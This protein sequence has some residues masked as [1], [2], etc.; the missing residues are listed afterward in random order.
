MARVIFSKHDVAAG[1][2]ER[3]TLFKYGD[4]SLYHSRGE[5]I[6]VVFSGKKKPEFVYTEVRS[7]DGEILYRKIVPWDVILFHESVSTFELYCYIRD[8]ISIGNNK[9][10]WDAVADIF[11]SRLTADKICG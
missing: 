5:P 7:P 4:W 8:L 1:I 11:A 10:M 3:A 9:I 2:I 6:V